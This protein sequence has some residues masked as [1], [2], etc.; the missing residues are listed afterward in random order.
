MTNKERDEQYEIVFDG[1]QSIIPER[2]TKPSLLWQSLDPERRPYN[3]TGLYAK[4]V[5]FWGS[6]SNSL[7][8]PLDTSE[9]GSS[10]GATPEAV[11]ADIKKGQEH[12]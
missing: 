1:R 9:D 5:D 3:K 7:D 2:E 12:P 6:P 10:A 8:N 4:T 11:E